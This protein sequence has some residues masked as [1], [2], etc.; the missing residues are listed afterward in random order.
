MMFYTRIWPGKT[1]TLC[2]TSEGNKERRRLKWE[3]PMKG[4]T[5]PKGIGTAEFGSN[6]C[7]W[8]HFENVFPLQERRS[9]KVLSP[10]KS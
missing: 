10:R 4:N 5:K 3:E 6:Y 8:Q 9:V 1:E 2:E 7:G